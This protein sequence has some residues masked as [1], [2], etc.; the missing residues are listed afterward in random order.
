MLI[1]LL[2]KSDFGIISRTFT[3]LQCIP[4]MIKSFRLDTKR[5]DL[6]VS[7]EAFTSPF[8][9][10]IMSS[11][12]YKESTVFELMNF[13]EAG[14]TYEYEDDRMVVFS[15]S[16]PTLQASVYLK[17]K[18]VMISENER[19]KL[20][21]IGK[22]NDDIELCDLSFKL[23]FKEAQMEMEGIFAT[24]RLLQNSLGEMTAFFSGSNF[25]LLEN[26]IFLEKISIEEI[27]VVF[28]ELSNWRLARLQRYFRLMKF[29]DRK[30]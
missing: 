25:L 12:T 22:I 18:P 20:F 11:S 2:Q 8:T 7:R 15:A 5:P 23:E 1:V 3:F 28:E 6:G 30:P 21:L 13:K 27:L 10:L 26:Y 9:A 16:A 17:F 29:K 19:A 14:R 4:T 24:P